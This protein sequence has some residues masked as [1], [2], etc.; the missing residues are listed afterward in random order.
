MRL[1]SGDDGTNEDFFSAAA[2]AATQGKDMRTAA[3]IR[4]EM[5]TDGDG[6]V[7]AAEH[8]ASADEDGDGKIDL[9]VSAL[10]APPPQPAPCRS[11]RPPSPWRR[12]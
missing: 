4:R 12:L 5:D 9:K 11:Q 7:S 8:F 10:P 1:A 3:E 2:I 6:V